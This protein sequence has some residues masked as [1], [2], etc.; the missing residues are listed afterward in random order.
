MEVYSEKLR[1]DIPEFLRHAHFEKSVILLRFGQ[2]I[3][4]DTQRDSRE[5]LRRTSEGSQDTLR[6]LL[7]AICVSKALD[8]L[9]KP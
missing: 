6:R 5:A 1:S 8:Q 7:E 9:C 4:L 2:N 3:H